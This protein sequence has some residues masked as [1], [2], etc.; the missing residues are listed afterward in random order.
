MKNCIVLLVF[1]IVLQPLCFSQCIADEG[2][3]KVDC[4]YDNDTTKITLGGNPT[5]SGGAGGYT[6]TW[7]TPKHVWIDIYKASYFLSDTTV[8]NPYLIRSPEDSTFFFLQVSDTAGNVCYDTVLVRWVNCFS[9]DEPCPYS[10]MIQP[11]DSVRLCNDLF[12]SK[13]NTFSWSPGQT[14]S[15]STT[16]SPYA[17]PEKSTTY[18]CTITIAGVCKFSFNNFVHVANSINE[19]ERTDAFSFSPNPTAGSIKIQVMIVDYDQTILKFYN[20]YGKELIQITTASNEINADLG[21]FQPGIYFLQLISEG[22]IV[23]TK[24]LILE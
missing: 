2:K 11:G 10:F 6:Y 19:A 17:K 8:A 7:S 22:R 9:L 1:L 13:P 21:Q 23:T 15:D 12:C 20:L 3:D 14:L 18:T 4:A 24:K 5:A 16:R